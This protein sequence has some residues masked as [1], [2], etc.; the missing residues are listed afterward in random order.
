MLIWPPQ[1]L[2]QRPR[3]KTENQVSFLAHEVKSN[4]GKISIKQID[5]FNL[6]CNP[7]MAASTSSERCLFRMTLIRSLRS[8]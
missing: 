6:E 8:I 1:V 3:Q 5:D 2:T 4:N 7:G